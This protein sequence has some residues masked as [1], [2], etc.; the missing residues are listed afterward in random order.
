MRIHCLFAPD[1]AKNEVLL[2]GR[3]ADGKC[4]AVSEPFHKVMIEVNLKLIH[5]LEMKAGCGDVT[6]DRVA[7]VNSEY[8]TPMSQR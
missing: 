1:P 7:Y 5:A 6:D 2:S 3:I 4:K 8:R